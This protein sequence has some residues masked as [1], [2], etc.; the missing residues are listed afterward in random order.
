MTPKVTATVPWKPKKFTGEELLKACEQARLK[1]REAC[2]QIADKIRC[3]NCI[4]NERIAQAIRAR[5]TQGE[6]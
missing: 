2:A 5:S 6:K 1:E 3:A 4:A